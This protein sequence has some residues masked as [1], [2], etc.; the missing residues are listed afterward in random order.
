[1]GA[2]PVRTGAGAG[3]A[4]PGRH[5]DN[6]EGRVS[7]PD[8]RID[9]EVRD[10]LIRSLWAHGWTAAAIAAAAHCSRQTVDRATRR[11]RKTWRTRCVAKIEEYSRLEGGNAAG[12]AAAGGVPARTGYG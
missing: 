2:E 7:L 4:E 3:R 6:D 1:M 5:R 10:A 11:L 12:I 9:R 8:P